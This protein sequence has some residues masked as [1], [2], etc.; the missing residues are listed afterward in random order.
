MSPFSL[1]WLDGTPLKGWVLVRHVCYVKGS[2]HN[3]VI[4]AHCI[5]SLGCMVA[6]I[7]VLFGSSIHYFVPNVSRLVVT[8]FLVFRW[9]DW[10]LLTSV[11]VFKRI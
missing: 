6:D 4:A 7:G 11:S 9:V 10:R 2:L 3:L 5:G 8:W 1:M